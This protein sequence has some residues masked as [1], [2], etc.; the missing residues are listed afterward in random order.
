[1]N[2]EWN[3]TFA[4]ECGMKLIVEN[5]I[6]AFIPNKKRSTLTLFMMKS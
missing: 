6:Y 4:S 1:M 5:S 3:V 2:F